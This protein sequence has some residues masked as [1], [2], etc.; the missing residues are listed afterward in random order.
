MWICC[1]YTSMFVC[2][3]VFKEVCFGNCK[4]LHVRFNAIYNI[5][6]IVCV[7]TKLTSLLLIYVRIRSF[8]WDLLATRTYK[9][10][11]T[12]FKKPLLHD[13]LMMPPAYYQNIYL[14]HKYLILSINNS[15]VYYDTTFHVVYCMVTI[16]LCV[17]VCY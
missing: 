1:R 3:I 11:Y 7:Y 9:H 17:C 12:T 5:V 14:L 10:I 8:I 2:V 13:E 16:H 6:Q 4:Y 15:K